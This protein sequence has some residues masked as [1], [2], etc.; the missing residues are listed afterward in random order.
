MGGKLYPLI[1]GV[2]LWSETEADIRH[3]F[4][5]HLRRLREAR[6]RELL[7]LG[8]ET[9]MEEQLD[10]PFWDPDDYPALDPRPP[11]EIKVELTRD[12]ER[13][14]VRRARRI[15]SA[16]GL[17]NRLASLKEADRK[18]IESRLSG[19][20]LGGPRTEHQADELAAALY[21]EAPWLGA[22]I[23]HIWL[24]ARQSA[25]EGLGLH[26]APIFLDGPPASGKSHLG[27]RVADLAQVP[28]VDV[29]LGK[30]GEAFRLAGTSRGWGTAVPGRPV[31]EILATGVANPVILVDETDK[32][33]VAHGTDG[34]RTSALNALLGLIEPG[35]AQR[36]ECVYYRIVFDL[37]RVNWLC[38]SNSV[39][40]LPEPLL[41]RL[42]VIPVQP[43]TPAD[44][45]G[46]MFREGARR[47]LEEESLEILARTILRA[48]S[49]ITLRH[50]MRALDKLQ[51]VRLREP[52]H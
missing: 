10:L 19:V 1:Y 15:V 3:R 2:R 41:S 20:T 46:V 18:L 45:C 13:R 14:I 40:L 9:P 37:S 47:G 4:E 35:S 11:L 39:R 33:G 42:R 34:Y 8:A 25:R 50:M 21:D 12:D 22:A 29:D 27:R 17:A 28:F 24:G 6:V 32:A 49:A 5:A 52:F 38:T 51:A 16:R 48:R 43:P 44:V 31:E 26:F 7:T 36:W 30:G 23:E